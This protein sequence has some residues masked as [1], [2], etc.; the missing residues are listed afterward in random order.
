MPQVFAYD[1][2]ERFVAGTVGEPGQ[3][4]FFLQAREGV[5][6]TTVALEKAQVAALAQ[7]ADEILD[8]VLRRGDTEVPALAPAELADQAPL[9]API[10]PE[11]QVGTLALA[12]D[13]DDSRLVIEA[14][15]IAAEPAGE[16]EAEAA[17][18]DEDDELLDRLIVRLTPGAAREF[19]R[20]SQALVAAGRPPCPFCQQPLDP[21][22]HVCP[23]SNGYRRR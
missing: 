23:R 14:L 8:A 17:D 11:F 19:V 13:E 10:A 15:A 9:E 16:D 12:W 21:Q 6:L 22:G 2:P 3:R 4:A 1:P 7:R 18:D 5:R 20:R